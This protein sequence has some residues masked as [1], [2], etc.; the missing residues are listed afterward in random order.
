MAHSKH[1]SPKHTSHACYDAIIVCFH[2]HQRLKPE[3]G[4]K[5]EWILLLAKLIRYPSEISFLNCF[6]FFPL[7]PLL[8]NYL[9]FGLH[10]LSQVS[11]CLPCFALTNRPGDDFTAIRYSP[12]PDLHKFLNILSINPLFISLLQSFSVPLTFIRR[13]YIST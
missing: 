7:A 9:T 8:V 11:S 10:L 3:V 2:R 4:W 1:T 13:L 12:I 6:F 5:G